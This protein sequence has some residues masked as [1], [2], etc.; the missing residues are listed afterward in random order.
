MLQALVC[1]IG[2]IAFP[3]TETEKTVGGAGLGLRR[4]LLSIDY[5]MLD[6][7]ITQLFMQFF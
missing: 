7:L 5:V 2:K 3:F 1:T 4:S 6:M